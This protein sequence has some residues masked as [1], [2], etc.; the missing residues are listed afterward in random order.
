MTLKGS[1]FILLTLDV[2]VMNSVFLM[3]HKNGWLHNV[4]LTN[5]FPQKSENDDNNIVNHHGKKNW[6][7]DGMFLMNN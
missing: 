6:A 2:S 1:S 4:Q 5:W 3:Y 7:D